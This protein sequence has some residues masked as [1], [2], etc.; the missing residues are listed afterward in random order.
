MSH[1][2]ILDHRMVTWL[3]HHI[4]N[5]QILSANVQDIV[6][7]ANRLTVYEHRYKICQYPLCNKKLFVM[8]VGME[9]AENAR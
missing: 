4:E 7:R 8:Y 5:P 3:K 9:D 1:L 6:A 2:E